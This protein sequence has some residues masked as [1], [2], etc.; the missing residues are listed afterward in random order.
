M[1]RIHLF[2]FEDLSWFPNWLRIALTRLINVMHQLLK[3]DD[4]LV[5]LLDPLLTKTNSNRIIDLCSGSG[6]PMPNVVERLDKE[7]NHKNL[8]L[9]LTDLYPNLL[10]ANKINAKNDNITY[11]TDPVDATN[12]AHTLKG[13]RTMVSSFHHMKPDD[14]RQ[15]LKSAFDNKQPICIFEISDNSY[16]KFL[17]WAPIIMNILTCLFVTPLVRP[18]T[19]Q[20]FVF[21]YLIPIIPLTFAWDGAVSNAR[22]YTINDLTILLKDLQ[23]PN[24]SWESG[25]IKGRGNK[26]YLIGM[27]V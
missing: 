7:K 20:Q 23:D 2:E 18:F 19:I 12:V 22:T 21:T 26:L 14:A 1:K 11:T 17:W 16:P 9:T 8:S 27:P 25:I 5:K 15:I 24:Y 6:G 10:I 13:L 3:S 4:E